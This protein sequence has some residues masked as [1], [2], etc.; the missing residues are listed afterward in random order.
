MELMRHGRKLVAKGL[1]AGAIGGLAG[2]AAKLV[3]E[4]VYP[5][6]TQG[7]EPPPAVLAEKVAGHPLTKTQKTL[8]T[9]GFHWTFGAGIG[10]V[11]GLA[12]EF[13]PLVTLGYGVV[14][15]EVVL[16]T[17][18]ESTLPMLG[19]DRPPLEQPLREHTSEAITHAM[20]G[21][22]TELVRRWLMRRWRARTAEAI[23]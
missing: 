13:S 23:S 5:P 2:S 10:A 18:H 7:Q 4:L 1:L 22:G 19:L 15:G 12:A 16:L 17:T 8:A 9:Q 20:Y 3:G 6:R 14:F 11:Y 21:A